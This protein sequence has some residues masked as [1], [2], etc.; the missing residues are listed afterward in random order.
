MH[1]MHLA[2]WRDWWEAKTPCCW[3]LLGMGALILSWRAGKEAEEGWVCAG[4]E[5][6][7]VEAAPWAASR[8]ELSTECPTT[9]GTSQGS[10]EINLMGSI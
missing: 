2:G 8:T 10:D 5:H 3:L 4:T 7:L 1:F 6:H 9:T